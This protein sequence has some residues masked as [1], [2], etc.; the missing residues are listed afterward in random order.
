MADAGLE[1]TDALGRR[2][3]RPD[4]PTFT[5]GRRSANDLQLIGTDVSRDHADA[6]VDDRSGGPSGPPQAGFAFSTP[7][8]TSMPVKS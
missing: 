2:L 8:W 4:K 3:V 7:I 5:I 1:V 6:I